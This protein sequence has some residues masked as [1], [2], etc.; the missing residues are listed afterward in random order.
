M[1]P[2]RALT[3]QL[4]ERR[5]WPLAV[6]LLAGIVA[7][8]VVLAR[9]ADAPS[10]AAAP[11]SS[12]SSAAP[13]GAA[14]AVVAPDPTV[15]SDTGTGRG[16]ARAARRDPFVQRGL[17]KPRTGTASAGSGSA[18]SSPAPTTS[19]STSAST[20]TS[21]STPPSSTSTGTST[22]TAPQTTAPSAVYV[23]TSVN[24]AF[25]RAGHQRA[26]RGIP[27]LTPLPGPTN[28]V[29]I[30]LGLV[31]G[32]RTAVFLIPSDAQPDGD[33]SC[34]PS[35][36]SCQTVHLRP[37]QRE[38]FDIAD[39]SGTVV[40]YQLDYTRATTR[41]VSTRAEARRSEVRG[42]GAGG[43]RST[44]P[45]AGAGGQARRA[46]GASRRRAGAAAAK[47]GGGASAVGAPTGGIEFGADGAPPHHRR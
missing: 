35:P 20:T 7:V 38:F 16:L 13:P 9:H 32:S 29:V 24:V 26:H 12:A 15:V 37:G 2:L 33:G 44:R 42:E 39:P 25:G 31:S 23:Q 43:S 34:H 27:R 28:P 40:E 18:G 22:Q 41:R 10:T 45:S 19:T 17:P 4:V 14:A 5:L 36:K 47:W 30:F 1:K 11:A 3:D 8:P 6:I 46:R 21:T